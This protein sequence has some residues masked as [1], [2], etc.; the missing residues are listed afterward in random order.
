MNA[1]TSFATKAV[2]F[3]AL[4]TSLSACALGLGV[5]AVG[6]GASLVAID[7]NI[8]AGTHASTAAVQSVENSLSMVDVAREI[9]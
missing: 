3:T 8:H 6:A 7:H 2:V 5:A 1:I 4:G 9:R